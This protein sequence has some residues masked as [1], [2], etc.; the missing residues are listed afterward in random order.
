LASVGN[1]EHAL[2]GLADAL[3]A[4]ID[5][6]RA[7]RALPGPIGTAVGRA[8]R[9]GHALTRVLTD[10]GLIDDTE[11][12]LV[13]AGEQMGALPLFL[14]EIVDGRRERRALF[15]KTLLAL[16][17]PVFLL[18]VGSVVLPLPQL[19]T[20]G[21]SPYLRSALP[22][23]IAV[24]VMLLVVVALSRAPALR[25]RLRPFVTRAAASLPVVGGVVKGASRASFYRTLARLTGAGLAMT[26]ALPLAFST[27]TLTDEARARCGRAIARGDELS[28]ALGETGA[29]PDD[30]LA[31]VANHALTG[32]LERGLAAL[33]TEVGERAARG[34][35]T[36]VVVFTGLIMALTFFSIA[37]G[38][39]ATAEE[40]IIAPLERAMSVD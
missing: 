36:L 40:A 22:L 9:E 8:A 38:I 35:T 7:A 23:P 5:V 31:R 20:D 25:A 6:E 28:H 24:V 4:G 18:V 30:E 11:R 12:A 33:A 15:Q 26:R 27:T 39:L 29:F 37:R 14:R 21:L 32:T 13:E 34:R 17:Y 19:F 3:A 16:A 10:T 2:L 1:I